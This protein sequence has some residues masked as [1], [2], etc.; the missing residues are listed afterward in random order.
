MSESQSLGRKGEELATAY[1]RKT[2][3]RIRH[4]NW[5]YGRKEIDIIA[6]NDEFIVF[7]EVKTRNESFYTTPA[8]AVNTDKQKSIIYAAEAYLRKYNID[9]ESRFDVITVV[10]DGENSELD[11][12]EN[13]FYPT[14][15]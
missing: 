14:L 12:I 3:F 10:T 4:T 13:A 2:G 7:V 8:S 15:R 11:H 5:T 1:L 6:E 9:R